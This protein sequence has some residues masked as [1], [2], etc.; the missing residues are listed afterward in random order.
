ME[1]VVHS[2]KYVS[3]K[4]SKE[5]VPFQQ[6]RVRIRNLEVC[7]NKYSFGLSESDKKSDSDDGF[8]FFKS[9]FDPKILFQNQ[10]Q[11][12]DAFWEFSNTVINIYA[13]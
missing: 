10:I 1:I 9:K 12:E 5:I 2:K 3:T 11:I 13:I 7:C 8:M 4:V 6:A